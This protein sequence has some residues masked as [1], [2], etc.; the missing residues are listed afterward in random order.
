M[1][2]MRLFFFPLL[3]LEHVCA[4]TEHKGTNKTSV[5]HMTRCS[6]SLFNEYIQLPLESGRCR[7]SSERTRRD[8]GPI[9]ELFYRDAYGLGKSFY[10]SDTQCLSHTFSLPIIGKREWFHVEKCTASRGWKRKRKDRETF[11]TIHRVNTGEV[12][13][14]KQKLNN[15]NVCLF[16]FSNCDNNTKARFRTRG[17]IPFETPKA[18]GDMN[19]Y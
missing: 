8:K 16:S 14:S 11:N 5:S 12:S 17:E 15:E 1:D 13:A 3:C 10:Q 2:V 6:L 4:P 19:H 9:R 7:L 18:G